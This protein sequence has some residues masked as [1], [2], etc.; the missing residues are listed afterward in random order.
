M[1]II[2]NKTYF[3]ESVNSFYTIMYFHSI[4]YIFMTM[5]IC[6]SRLIFHVCSLITYIL[7]SQFILSHVNHI[8]WHEGSSDTF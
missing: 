7:Q 1:K 8:E 4:K 6:S 5:N 3:N 2:T